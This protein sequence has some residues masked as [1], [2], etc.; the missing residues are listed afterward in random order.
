MG[1]KSS[2]LG[3]RHSGAKGAYQDAR[4]WALTFLNAYVVGNESEQEKFRQM[5]SV[6]GNA[7]DVFVKMVSR[8]QTGYLT[9]SLNYY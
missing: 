8:Y 1:R 7:E 3:W 9:S 5:L 2:V 4:A 6:K